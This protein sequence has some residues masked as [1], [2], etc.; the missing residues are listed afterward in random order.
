MERVDQRAGITPRPRK[1]ATTCKEDSA[2]GLTRLFR[3]QEQTPE[4]HD[5]F[6]DDAT[7]LARGVEEQVL[8]VKC[9]QFG[10]FGDC[11]DVMAA[12]LK[13]TATVGECISSSRSDIRARRAAPLRLMPG[14]A[15]QY[16]RPAPLP[17]TPRRPGLPQRR[18]PRD[19]PSSNAA[20]LVLSRQTEQGPRRSPRSRQGPAHRSR[21]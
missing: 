7:G 12:V 4:V 1:G 5:V 11:D 13:A 2:S 20:Q 17:R 8:V 10:V 19:R 15:A 3:T 6:C 9:T 16:A 21:D 14:A 18:S